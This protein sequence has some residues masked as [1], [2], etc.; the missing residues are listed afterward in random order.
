[1]GG[2]SVITRDLICGWG[3]QKRGEEWCHM[4]RVSPLLLLWNWRPWTKEC[5]QAAARWK[6]Q[7]NRFSSRA[8][9]RNAGLMMIFFFFPSLGYSCLGLPT[10]YS[11]KVPSCQCRRYGCYPWVRRFTGGGNGNPLQY[12]SLENPMGMGSCRLHVRGVTKSRTWLSTHTHTHS[13]FTLLC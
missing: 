7:G 1:M 10:W 11:S 8:S 6:G 4:K 2:S 9:R 3:R 12:S 5:G 13:C